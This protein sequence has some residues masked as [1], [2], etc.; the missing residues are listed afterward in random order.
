MVL[1]RGLEAPAAG[2]A[3]RDYQADHVRAFLRAYPCQVDFAC[4]HLN[5]LHATLSIQNIGKVSIFNNPT[6]CKEEP[7][8]R[9]LHGGI[10]AKVWQN[11]C[12]LVASDFHAEDPP[13]TSN[14]IVKIN[15]RLSVARGKHHRAAT[16][17]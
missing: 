3:S 10:A 8:K 7:S 4:V 13:P 9:P 11:L 15:Y 2:Q 12:I 5:Y 16:A 17:I 6:L 1:E 14:R